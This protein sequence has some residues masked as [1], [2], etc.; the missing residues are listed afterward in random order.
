GQLL[1]VLARKDPP[2][3]RGVG[4]SPR[5]GQLDARPQPHGFLGVGAQEQLG[6]QFRE[7]GGLDRVPVL[8]V[9]VHDLALVGREVFGHGEDSGGAPAI[10]SASAFGLY[11]AITAL[12][13]CGGVCSSWLYSIE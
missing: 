9:P 12:W 2:H 3:S 10:Y 5:D 4:A 1:H 7:L 11:A 13:M 8:V 6:R